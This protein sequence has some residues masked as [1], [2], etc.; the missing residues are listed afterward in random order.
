LVDGKEQQ[1]E[2]NYEDFPDNY[3]PNNDDAPEYFG[4]GPNY[5]GDV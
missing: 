2:Y 1:Q 3:I 5:N 4:E